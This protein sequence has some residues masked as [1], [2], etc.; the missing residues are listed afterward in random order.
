MSFSGVNGIHARLSAILT[1][2]VVRSSSTI[3]PRSSGAIGYPS[4]LTYCSASRCSI[5]RTNVTR[6]RLCGRGCRRARTMAAWMSAGMITIVRPS[7][8]T[9]VSVCGT[10]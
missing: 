2:R 7:I 8:R 6:A 4:W 10:R 9:S 1:S 3:S 5:S